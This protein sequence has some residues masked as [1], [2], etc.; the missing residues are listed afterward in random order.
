[1]LEDGYILLRPYAQSVS[2]QT[3][4]FDNDVREP[5]SYG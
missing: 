3:R 5:S 1:V 2:S 4:A